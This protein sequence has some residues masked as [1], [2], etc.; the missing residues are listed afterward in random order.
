M[1]NLVRNECFGEQKMDKLKHFLVAFVVIALTGA[2]AAKE[3]QTEAPLRLAINLVDGSRVIGVPNIASVKVETPYAKMEISLEQVASLELHDNR[4]TASLDLRNGDKITGA[5]NLGRLRI[6]TIAGSLTVPVHTMQRFDVL[7]HEDPAVRFEIDKD[8]TI[9]DKQ[10]GV[11]F[12]RPVPDSELYCETG[13]GWKTIQIDVRERILTDGKKHDYV[14][15]ADYRG[16]ADCYHI[17]NFYLVIDGARYRDMHPKAGPP[18]YKYIEGSEKHPN[19]HRTTG[20]ITS[21]PS[22]TACKSAV[23]EFELSDDVYPGGVGT[24]E[25]GTSV[26]I[27]FA[28]VPSANQ[29]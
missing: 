24:G 26:S 18:N 2:A 11:T 28:A 5:V 20:F 3:D 29:K 8:D 19:R 17:K 12:K 1:A 15:A 10:K 13:Q 7:S 21:V 4:E 27:G 22:L 9:H 16:G 6:E 23:L 25:D 14:V